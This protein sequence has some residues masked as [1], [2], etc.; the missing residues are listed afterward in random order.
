[1]Q[2]LQQGDLLWQP[3]EESIRTAN[4]TGYMQWLRETKALPFASYH[5]LWQWS[6]TDLEGFW[7]SIWDYFEVRASRQ[8]DC[9]LKQR[10]MPGANWFPGARLNYAE[11]FFDRGA[12]AVAA[13]SV[14]FQY[15]SEDAPIVQI[16][17]AEIR[18]QT[19]RLARALRQMG[20][21]P[22]DRV[23]AY[24]PHI[25]ETIIALFAVSRY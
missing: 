5:A 10:Q 6:V 21:Q 13:D 17:W 24:M 22:G 8:P 18:Q 7:G 4:L 25:P 14:A 23:V 16:T 11:N 15:K 20:V 9:V 1:M 2:S 19:A 3:D 12:Q